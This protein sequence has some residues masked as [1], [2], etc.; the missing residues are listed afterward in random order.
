MITMTFCIINV[1]TY[2]ILKTI[3]Y[4]YVVKMMTK[5]WNL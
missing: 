5:L 3:N 2:V 4:T 1:I